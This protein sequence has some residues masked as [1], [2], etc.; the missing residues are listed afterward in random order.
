MEMSADVKE[1]AT[2]LAKAQSE[3]ESA[4]KD[5]SG[6]GYK[7]SDLATVIAS[8]RPV[9]SKNGLAVIQLIGK[10]ENN[11]VTMTTVLTHSSGQYFKTL[12]SLPA[13]EMKGCNTAQNFG[14]TLSYLRRYAYQAIIGQPS[15]DNDANSNGFDKPKAEA[16]APPAKANTATVAAKEEQPSEAPSTKSTRFRS[17]RAKGANNDI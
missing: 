5:E 14:A 12:S 3:L 17:N 8:S 13:I 11:A 7:Y 16:K 15:E 2:A 4:K 1:I 6:Y 9:L 10:S